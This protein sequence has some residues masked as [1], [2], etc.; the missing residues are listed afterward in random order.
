MHRALENCDVLSV[1]FMT[2]IE[3]AEEA[4]I[5]F[6]QRLYMEARLRATLLQCALVCRQFR[7]PALNALWWRLDNL[8]PLIRLLPCFV[9]TR[10]K[11]KGSATGD[12]LYV[13]MF[14]II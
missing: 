1:L 9:P 11:R 14:S 8:V 4:D 7:D 10:V 13:S 12:T 5:D 2:M 3:E 6:V